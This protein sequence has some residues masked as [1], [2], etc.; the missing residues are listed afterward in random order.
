MTPKE[1]STIIAQLAFAEGVSE[2][3]YDKYT[4][5]QLQDRLEFLFGGD[6]N[7]KNN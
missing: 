3:V 6:N 2:S 1:R 7:D 4:D 5:Q